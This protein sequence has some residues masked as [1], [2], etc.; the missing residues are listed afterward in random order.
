MKRLFL[1]LAAVLFVSACAIN[2]SVARLHTNPAKYYNK[3]VSVSGVVTSAFNIPLVPFHFYKVDDGTGEVTVLSSRSRVPPR[4]ARVSVKGKVND[5][6]MF[7]GRS[8]GLHITE[9]DLHVK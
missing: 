7:G 1:V 8:I 9:E 6:A 5:V 2:T 4:G 3:S